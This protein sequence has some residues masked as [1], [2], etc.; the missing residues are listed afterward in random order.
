MCYAR[1]MF[2]IGYIV[3]T[4]LDIYLTVIGFIR[5]KFLGLYVLMG[6]PFLLGVFGILCVGL[7]HLM[8]ANMDSENPKLKPIGYV[9]VTL[10]PIACFWAPY[11]A[12]NSIIFILRLSL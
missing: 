9:F 1:V 11:L 6:L 3:L 8:V 5:L 2:S 7:W 10:Y 12:Y 4:V